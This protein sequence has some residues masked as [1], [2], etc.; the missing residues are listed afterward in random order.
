MD[1]YLKEGGMR[2]NFPYDELDISGNEDY[3]FRPFQLMVASVAGCSASVFR[4]ILDKKRID[5]DDLKIS[6]D[7]ERN[8]DEAN[9]IEAIHL[10]FSVKGAHLDREKLEK[11]MAIAKKNCSMIRSI[12]DSVKITETLEIINLSEI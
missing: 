11:S 4:K 8:A 5:I 9:K 6:A 12:E 1:F 10:H 2:V 3:G 7:V